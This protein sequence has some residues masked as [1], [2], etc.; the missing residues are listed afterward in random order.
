TMIG[1]DA[2]SKVRFDDA[3]MSR[4][5][6]G[7]RRYGAFIFSVTRFTFNFFQNVLHSKEGPSAYDPSAVMYLVDSSLFTMKKGPVRVVTTGIASGETIMPVNP[8]HLQLP[9]WSGKPFV[10][11]AMDVDAERFLKKYES[12]M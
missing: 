3:L 5:K 8:G 10:T 11:A 1:L 12:I 2:I 7:N 4:I 9:A 6:N